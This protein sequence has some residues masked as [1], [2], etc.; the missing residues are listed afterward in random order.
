MKRAPAPQ[1][2]FGFGEEI[3]AVLLRLRGELNA[4]E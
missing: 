3:I 2:L 1:A 4:E